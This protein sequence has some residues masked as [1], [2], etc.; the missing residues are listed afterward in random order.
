MADINV[1]A[2]SEA[3][4]EKMDRDGNNGTD[5]ALDNLAAGSVGDFV[6]DYQ[7]PT[8]ENNYTWYRLYKSGWIEQGGEVSGAYQDNYHR[9][10]TFVKPFANTNYSV[11]FNGEANDN[12]SFQLDTYV[13]C[14]YLAGGKE[15]TGCIA[16]HGENDATS[17]CYWVA[18]GMSAQD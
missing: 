11:M 16:G 2:L 5:A 9:Q 10:I 13:L 12:D 1:G 14:T 15:T 4:N 8:Q 7:M 3:I 18:K 17:K 6:I